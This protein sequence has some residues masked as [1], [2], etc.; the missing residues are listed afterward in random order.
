MSDKV[1]LAPA[2]KKQEQFINSDCTVTLCG[3]AAKSH[4]SHFNKPI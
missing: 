3:G 1:I 4:W 2:S